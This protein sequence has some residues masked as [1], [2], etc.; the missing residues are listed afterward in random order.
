[1]DFEKL[2]YSISQAI[3]SVAGA[4]EIKAGIAVIVAMLE[5]HAGIFLIFNILV[6]LDLVSKWLA[7]AKPLT[8]SGELV[9]ELKAIPEAHRRGIISS[10]KMKTRFAGKIL[11]YLFIAIAAAAVDG[12]VK[13]AGASSHA[14]SLCVGYL[15]ATELLSIIENLNDAGVSAV[16]DLAA[17]VK[18]LRGR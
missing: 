15:A 16:S 11:V 10:E 7:L 8:E 12:I 1:M 13:S 9:D 2:T 4:W 14:F 18:K 5:Y 6:I 3:A 17:A